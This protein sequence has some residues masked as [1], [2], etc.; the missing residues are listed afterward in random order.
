MLEQISIT[1]RGKHDVGKTTTASLL[2]MFLEENGYTNVTL[3][4]IPPL[5]TEQKDAF[6]NRFCRNRER[7]VVIQ[8][9]LEEGPTPEAE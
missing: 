1:V 9:E 8:V 6:W 7:P 3:K 4:D 5:P 2:K